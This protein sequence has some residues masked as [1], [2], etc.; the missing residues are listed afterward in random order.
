M[1]KTKD[2]KSGT[3][4]PLISL[5]GKD[6]LQ[7]AHRLVWFREEHPRGKILSEI[8]FSDETRATVKAVIA[9][10]DMATG[11][12]LE[13]SS[14]HKSEQKGRFP[15]FL[16]K[17]ETGAIGRA[18]AVAGYGTQFEPE[19]DEEERIVDSPMESPRKASASPKTIREAFEAAK[20]FMAEPIAQSLDKVINNMPTPVK[21]DIT[22]SESRESLQRRIT[23]FSNVI[24]A[25]EGRPVD[26]G[27]TPEE[28]AARK[29]KLDDLKAQMKLDY[30][31]SAA[32]EL[33][34]EQLADLLKKLE[35]Q[36]QGDNK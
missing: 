11:A 14:G 16:E 8:V 33:T 17:A 9:V 3:K 4:L 23:G 10:P 32:K 31:V 22:P 19:F 27:G 18:L 7:V 28:L 15:D 35:Q 29:A 5:K 12:W 34:D 1:S 21:G 30:G 6:Y 20:P 2:L 13:L 24:L 26:K 25:K 36:A